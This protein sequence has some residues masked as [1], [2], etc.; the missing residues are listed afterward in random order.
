MKSANT[1]ALF[2]IFY[3]SLF[4][5]IFSP[6]IAFTYVE[7]AAKALK[8]HWI[9]TIFANILLVIIIYTNTIVH[10]YMLADNRHYLFYVWN[11]FYG[12]FSWA[13]FVVIP[14][15][16]LSSTILWYSIS[17]RS[18]GF[19]VMYTLCTI[20]SIALQQLIEIRYFILPFLIARISSS[21]VKFKLLILE[22]ITYSIINVIVF[23]L[24][25]TKE[26]YWENYN[27]VQRLIW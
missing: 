21:S 8:K 24:F 27:Y 22:L 19:Q 15:Y 16:L 10:P 17:I 18:A 12:R 1:I 25:S 20:V 9:I 14:F 11:K 4:F 2:Q 13:R 23:Y 26:I 5:L 7:L 3:F 6:S